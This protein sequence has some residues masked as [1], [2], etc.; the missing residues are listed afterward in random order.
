[1]LVATLVAGSLCGCKK[2]G[3]EETSATTTADG[4]E[5]SQTTV[6]DM[7]DPAP[8][9]YGK[10][11]YAP[12]EAEHIAEDDLVM[13]V[14]NEILIVVKDGVTEEQVRELAEKYNSEIVGAIEITG[15]YQLRLAETVTKEELD[16]TLLKIKGEDIVTGASYNYV[17]P[18]S[19][20]ADTEERDG[21]SYGKEWKSDLQIAEG[22]GKSWGFEAINTLGA[23]DELNAHKDQVKPVKVGLI[24]GGFDT[25]HDDLAFAEV[26]YDRGANNRTTDLESDVVSH[27]THV[28]GIMAARCDNPAGICGVYPYGA[29]NLYGV[30]NG[31]ATP[32]EQLNSVMY[33]K[34]AYAELIVRNVK[35][36]NVS[37][38]FN[39][40]KF[41]EFKGAYNPL[42][43]SKDYGKVKEMM[44]T[45]SNI[46]KK[47]EE[48]KALGDFLERM[49]K[50]NKY[51][52][53]IVSAAG[54]DSNLT[55]GH[56]DCR[57]SSWNTLIRREDFPDVYDRIIVVGSVDNTLNIA[58]DSN[59]GDRVDVYAPGGGS[60]FLD[61]LGDF[62]CNI[63]VTPTV[64]D[65]L[66]ANPDIYSTLP[67]NR[68][69][70]K[71]GTSMA[72]PH[73]AGVAAMVWSAN[74]SLT[75]AEVKEII[76]KEANK[77]SLCTSCN[78]VDA[79]KAVSDAFKT[80]GTRNA[81]NPENGIV[82]SYVVERYHEENKIGK[83]KIEFKNIE[84]GEV[85][86]LDPTKKVLPETDSEGHFE[87]A[88]PEGKY[89]LTVKADGYEDYEWPDG[90]D[91]ENPLVVQK[92]QV[93]YLENWIKL[94]RPG[95]KEVQF[96]VFALEADTLKPISEKKITLTIS[97]SELTCKNPEQTTGK[98]GSVIFDIP[99]GEKNKTITTKVTLHIDG[100][101]DFVLDDYV[102]ENDA[103]DMLLQAEA[104]FEKEMTVPDVNDD[105]YVVFGRYEQDGDTS[106]GKEPIE[107][108]VLEENEN[109][110]LVI[111]RYILDCVPFN[112]KYEDVTWETSSLRE[113][114]NK[115]FLNEA[116][117]EA[118]QTLI[119]KVHLKN[120]GV[121]MPGGNDTDDQ[122]FCLSLEEASRYY[123][124]EL[125]KYAFFGFCKD[126]ITLPTEYAKAHG[127]RT[128]KAKDCIDG[129]IGDEY[130]F[131]GYA[132]KGYQASIA[133]LEGTYWWLRTMGW[134]RD[135]CAVFPNGFAGPHY[136]SGV[137]SEGYGVRPVL[138]IG[139]GPEPEPE[140]PTT[141]EEETKPTKPN[142][143]TEV[144][145]NEVNFPAEAFRDYVREEFDQDDNGVLSPEELSQAEE[146]Y[147]SNL[148]LTGL[149][150]I[151]YFYN[152]QSL[153]LRSVKLPGLD[154]S[155]NTALSS[156]VCDRVGLTELDIRH[157][158]E[159]KELFCSNN[160]LTS[161][162]ISHNTALETL[163]CE[164]N[165]LTALDVSQNPKLVN[166]ICY[167]NSLTDLDV[168]H[169]PALTYLSCNNNN[170]TDLDLSHNSA[171]EIL[172]CAHNN[173][174]ALDISNNT[175]LES[176][177][178]DQGTEI[179]GLT[180]KVRVDYEKK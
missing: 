131:D 12:V 63:A 59:G 8:G 178:A 135:A 68:Y 127:M 149:Q 84:T 58:H 16:N 90:E 98:D 53:V 79:Q 49:L 36:I 121:E 26:F 92:G 72:A 104:L 54:N 48:G 128:F 162:D 106:N 134:D 67:G 157:N 32:E 93:K 4:N 123:K 21:F 81:V 24:D 76:T 46:L 115:D 51:D 136:E 168:S 140:T 35:V 3:E 120:S 73:V 45:P 151:E 96:T 28:A 150:G 169:N 111:S 103:V 102:F 171:L 180:S 15:D 60:S 57:L 152:L 61:G 146:I 97:N 137:S 174:T 130:W 39:W 141:E 158:T 37:W 167:N 7:N 110:K 78:M 177:I 6:V 38:G 31:F 94:K 129:P 160:K 156:L 19:G 83:A 163:H 122:V 18:I 138:W 14:D 30:S 41:S 173:V 109:G 42:T 9:D 55:V 23:W 113:W 154:I 2:G 25:A 40:Y 133:D 44:E 116:F 166:L 10:L 144:E 56:I 88:L 80:K 105:G 27:G 71:S 22:L 114:L 43:D 148:E 17:A 82:M 99:M 164:Y 91:L 65:L 175:K 34:I 142:P 13:Y 172:A 29:Y 107:W 176:L 108:V 153:Q 77:S 69:G 112:N 1:M 86:Y 139:E 66:R 170:L 179:T 62:F 101:K 95:K 89:T 33:L 147:L 52:F 118:E 125:D 64:R 161:L 47:S 5:P 75:G 70:T 11:Y 124:F 132:P 85:A 87:V 145:I 165:K 100:Y 119:P 143:G 50:K 159:L 155:Q 20:N 117:Y 126:L 74:N